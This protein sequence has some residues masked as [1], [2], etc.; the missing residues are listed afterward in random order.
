[1]RLLE[2]KATVKVIPIDRGVEVKITTAGCDRV[3]VKLE[4]VCTSGAIVR[5][6]SFIIDA[7]PGGNLTVTD[8]T[9]EVRKGSSRIEVGTAFADHHYT[10]GMR[11][12]EPQSGTEFTFYFTDA[13]PVDRTIRIR[14]MEP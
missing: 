13:T 12:S 2:F 3:P 6:D 4:F 10:A 14:K 1:V 8:G 7:D 9:V 5:G 11:G